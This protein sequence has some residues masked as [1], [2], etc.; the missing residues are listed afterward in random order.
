[1]IINLYNWQLQGQVISILKF[2][3]KYES[4]FIFV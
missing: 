4:S 1:M 3:K 2:V